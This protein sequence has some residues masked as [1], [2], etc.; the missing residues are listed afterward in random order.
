MIVN[1]ERQKSRKLESAKELN[2]D[3]CTLKDQDIKNEPANDCDT[4]EA[5][6][7]SVHANEK[8]RNGEASAAEEVIRDHDDV[9]NGIFPANDQAIFY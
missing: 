6:D 3:I 9:R 7:G 1:A 5:D 4:F 8:S 2:G